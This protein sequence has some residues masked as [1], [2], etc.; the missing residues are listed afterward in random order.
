MKLIYRGNTYNYDPMK[1]KN[2]P[3]FP[4]T[5]ESPYK[6]IYRGSTYQFDPTIAQLDNS[7][8]IS[9]ELIY[10]G[11]SYQVNRNE[12]DRTATITNSFNIFNRKMSMQNTNK[13]LV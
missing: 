8:S 7:K 13:H 11:N 6:L 3:S 5:G 2:R 1:A 10:R 4:R 9:Y 12:I